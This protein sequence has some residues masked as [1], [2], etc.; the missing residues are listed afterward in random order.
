MDT[1]IEMMSKARAAQISWGQ[2][3]ASARCS[4]LRRLRLQIA[5]KRDEIVDIVCKETGKPPLDALGG[6]VLV[7]LEQLRYYEGRA[8]RLLRLRKVGKPVLLFHGTRFYEE[9]EPHGVVL[10]YAPANYPFQLSVVPMATALFAGNAVIVKCSERTPQVARLIRGLCEKANLPRDLV[11][12]ADDGPE[13]AVAYIDAHPDFVFFTGCSENGRA[14]AK[15]SADQLIPTALEL[16]GKDAAAVFADCNIERAI[17]GV[18]YGAFSN[19]GQVCVGIK[20]L[21]AERSIYSEFLA[22]L[23][24]EIQ[25]LRVGQSADSDLGTLQGINANDRLAAQVEDALRRGATLNHPQKDELDGRAPILLSDVPAES[26]IL[27]EETFGPVLCTA[28]FKDE[29]EAISL[30]NSSPFALSASVWT[31]TPSRAKRVAKAVSAGSCAVNDVIRNI[32]NPHAS[33]GGNRQSGYGRY[34]GPQGLYTFSRIK[35]VMVASGKASRE[36][37]WFPFK[38]KTFDRLNMFLGIRHEKGGWLSLFRR[39]FIFT[40]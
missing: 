30:M 29:A 24:A 17:E 22:R 28:P 23:T 3:S 1:P 27:S 34:H 20:R 33:F 25:R 9:F 26:R 14:V 21:Y 6:D 11:Q 13:S 18:L 38:P 39:L 15:R 4:V 19:A 2:Q 8:T 31:G 5:E 7:T 16:G 10:I 37:N 36:I 40:L 35:S 32:G 12:I